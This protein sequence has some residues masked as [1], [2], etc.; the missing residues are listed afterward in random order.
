MKYPSYRIETKRCVL[1][2]WNPADAKLLHASITK[3]V[4]HLKE[5]MPFVHKEPLTVEDR[6]EILRRFRSNFDASKDFVYG[7]FNRDESKVIGGTG[8]HTHNGKYAY[9][10]GYW[11]D[12]EE[13][14]K[15]IVTE[16]SKALIKVGFMNEEIDRFEIK[17]VPENQKSQNVPK[18]LGFNLECIRK[19]V[20]TAFEGEFRDFMVWVLFRSEYHGF[21]DNDIKIFDVFGD[22]I[23]LVK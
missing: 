8:L 7:I 1:R 20:N 11:I 18:K 15:G 14:G 6:I 16:I 10:I 5:F 23:P 9:E 12:K 17:C 3:N 13:C 21:E 19:R 2:C 4:D 22:E